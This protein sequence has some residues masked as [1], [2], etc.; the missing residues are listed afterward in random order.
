MVGEGK[1]Y[2]KSQQ[3]QVQCPEYKKDLVRKSVP[4]HRQRQHGGARGG[5]G[6]KDNKGDRGGKPRN[7]R[8]TFLSK[9]GPR[10][11]PVEGCSGRSATRSAMRVHFFHQPVWDIVVI[12]E[13]GNLPH[14]R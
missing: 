12:L 5:A 14:P 11:C 7:F 8:M 3:E 2:Q 10:P 6:H 4:T 13:E 1:S 9:A